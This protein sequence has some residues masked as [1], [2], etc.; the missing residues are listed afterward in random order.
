MAADAT[1][2]PGSS[3]G[4]HRPEQAGR[5]RGDSEEGYLGWVL[6]PEEAGEV[7]SGVG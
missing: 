7:G 4:T 6:K 2:S 1:P 5:W 3:E